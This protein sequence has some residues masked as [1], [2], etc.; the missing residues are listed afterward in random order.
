MNNKLVNLNETE[1]DFSA[2][3][4]NYNEAVQIIEDQKREL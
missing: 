3:Q 4:K 2:L 1:E